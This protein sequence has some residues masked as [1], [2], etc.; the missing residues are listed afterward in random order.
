M[1]LL[2]RAGQ[3]VDELEQLEVSRRLA[4][5]V[6]GFN[7]R[8][9]ELEKAFQAFSK[10]EK[11]VNVFRSRSIQ[12]TLSMNLT[13]LR[14][15]LLTIVLA[16]E[17]DPET[18]LKPDNTLTKTFW[19]PL[20]NYPNQI[21]L[22]LELNWK[23]YAQ[24]LL[25]RLDNELIEIFE[26]LPSTKTQ[27]NTIRQ[28]QQQA[29]TLSSSLPTSEHDIDEL[30]RMVA[31]IKTQWQGLQTTDI[32]AS[33]LTFLKAVRS[34]GASLQLFTDEVRQWLV[35]KQLTHAFCISLASSSPYR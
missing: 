32:P 30:E 18:L 3:L 8:A 20:K 34:G 23:R 12:F 4:E 1:T 10:L 24:N 35:D 14:Q 5:N 31:S 6:R 15:T 9:D 25:P 21:N 17:N 2:K 29:Y 13:N 33:V 26:K 28:L 11:L 16:Y 22:D 7:T 19:N 27:V